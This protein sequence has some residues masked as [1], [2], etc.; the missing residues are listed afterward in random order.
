MTRPEPEQRAD[1]RILLLLLL[2]LLFYVY[3]NLK[4][5]IEMEKKENQLPWLTDYLPFQMLLLYD[6]KCDQVNFKQ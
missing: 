3:M 2:L 5:Y 1:H 6:I 4:Y